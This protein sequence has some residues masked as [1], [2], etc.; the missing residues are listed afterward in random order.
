MSGCFIHEWVARAGLAACV[1]ITVATGP[2]GG[3]EDFPVE[4]IQELFRLVEPSAPSKD[5]ATPKVAGGEGTNGV[6]KPSGVVGGGEADGE[7]TT[8]DVARRVSRAENRMVLKGGRLQELDLFFL[9]NDLELMFSLLS[10]LPAK[11]MVVPFSLFPAVE[12]VAGGGVRVEP[13]GLVQPRRSGNPLE[14]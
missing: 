6:V 11:S 14:R 8:N 13:R 7:G 9:H 10:P 3:E 4:A 12:E 1:L 5:F 2:A